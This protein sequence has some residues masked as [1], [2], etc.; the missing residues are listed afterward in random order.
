ML[1]EVLSA[2]S[3]KAPEALSLFSGPLSCWKNLGALANL[4]SAMTTV[5]APRL[6]C[7]SCSY[8]SM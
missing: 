7:H 3:L 1:L 5:S 6:P 8:F 4:C 2:N